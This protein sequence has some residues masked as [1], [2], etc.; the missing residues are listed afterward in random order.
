MTA[1]AI[2]IDISLNQPLLEPQATNQSLSIFKTL[3]LLN[4]CCTAVTFLAFVGRATPTDHEPNPTFVVRAPRRD[5]GRPLQH[6]IKSRDS[7]ETDSCTRTTDSALG[8]GR[9]SPSRPELWSTSIQG[10]S[11]CCIKQLELSL[12]SSRYQQHDVYKQS[13]TP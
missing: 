9:E 8:D 2:T 10:G 3:P 11:C 4:D 13:T 6:R 1:G 5:W 7:V 12:Q